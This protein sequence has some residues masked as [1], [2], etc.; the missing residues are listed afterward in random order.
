MGNWKMLRAANGVFWL[1][2]WL[3][4]AM[5]PVKH[6][7]ASIVIEKIKQLF[8]LNPNIHDIPKF[9]GNGIVIITLWFGLDWVIRKREKNNS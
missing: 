3:S 8:I 9:V 6:T 7:H 1:W 5:L 4:S 2:M